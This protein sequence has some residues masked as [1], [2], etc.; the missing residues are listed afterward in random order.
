ME[1]ILS[2][3]CVILRNRR[4][5]IY[6]HIYMSFLSVVIRKVAS[7]YFFNPLSIRFCRRQYWLMRCMSADQP[8]T[9]AHTYINNIR[10]KFNYFHCSW[11]I[12]NKSERLCARI[13]S[14]DDRRAVS[15]LY[16][17]MVWR[18][19]VASQPVRSKKLKVKWTKNNRLLSCYVA[20]ISSYQFLL[21]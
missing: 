6:M 17:R 3:H 12:N 7:N 1:Q 14:S 9:G 4:F 2:I 11:Y 13:V 20:F 18:L 5:S 8:V 21:F 10:Y 15:P 16:F 19:V